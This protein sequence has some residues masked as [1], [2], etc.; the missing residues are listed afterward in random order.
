MV[1]DQLLDGLVVEHQR[2]RLPHIPDAVSVADAIP[3]VGRTP[4]NVVQRQPRLAVF[5]NLACT[6]REPSELI[7]REQLYR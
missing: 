3:A 1:V 4:L 6:W 2:T 7:C 5:D